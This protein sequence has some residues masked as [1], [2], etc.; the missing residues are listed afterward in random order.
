MTILFW[1]PPVSKA[2]AALKA[3]VM[4]MSF[5]SGEPVVRSN[6]LPVMTIPPKTVA[7][8]SRVLRYNWTSKEDCWLE[9]GTQR[10]RSSGC[11]MRLKQGP[12]HRS[13]AANMA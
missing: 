9:R 8:A 5:N 12:R 11:Y 6:A 3:T 1:S 4:M 13:Y 10:N 7:L 2:S